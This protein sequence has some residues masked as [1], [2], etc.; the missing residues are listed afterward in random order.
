MSIQIKTKHKGFGAGQWLSGLH[1]TTAEDGSVIL[2]NSSNY[3]VTIHQQGPYAKLNNGTES[4]GLWLTKKQ[5]DE[6][7]S[8]SQHAA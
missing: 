2:V 8:V 7:V 5:Y 6:A 1:T 3:A 4:F